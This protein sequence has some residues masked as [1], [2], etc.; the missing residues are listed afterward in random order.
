MLVIKSDQDYQ[1][2]SKSSLLQ[3]KSV[4]TITRSCASQN[5][6]SSSFRSEP[7]DPGQSS[8]SPMKSTSSWVPSN[9]RAPKLYLSGTSEIQ[10]QSLRLKLKSKYMYSKTLLKGYPFE[11]AILQWTCGLYVKLNRVTFRVGNPVLRAFY[12]Q[13][14]GVL[15]RGVLLYGRIRLLMQLHF[16]LRDFSRID[17]LSLSNSRS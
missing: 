17:I 13:I 3:K 8:T 2:R 10:K 1:P 7:S 15:S 9:I 12:S 5:V 4:I 11:R 16:L 14:T 6:R